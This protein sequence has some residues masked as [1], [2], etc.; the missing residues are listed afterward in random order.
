MKIILYLLESK[1]KKEDLSVR[2]DTL[3]KSINQLYAKIYSAYALNLRKETSIFQSSENY[4]SKV[5]EF[6]SLT[7]KVINEKYGFVFLIGE[8]DNIKEEKA[9]RKVLDESIYS[10]KMN[11]DEESKKLKKVLELVYENERL[12]FENYFEVENFY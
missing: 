1:I 9:N 12:K 3:E 8:S 5:Q 2:F 4:L 10:I 6:L 11:I 7:A